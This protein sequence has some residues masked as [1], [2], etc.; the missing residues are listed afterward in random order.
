MKADDRDERLLALGKPIAAE[1]GRGE[2]HTY[3][4]RLER[5]QYLQVA[6][7]PLG[8]EVALALTEPGGKRLAEAENPPG[9]PR[10]ER[11]LAIAET[12]GEH[13]VEV[14][15]KASRATA[16]RY[17]VT[18]EELRAA[19]TRDTCRLEAARAFA[20]GDRLTDEGTAASLA[21]AM[22]RLKDALQFWRLGEDLSGEAKT[23]ANIG[24]VHFL[25]GDKPKALES[26]AEALSLMEAVGD[27]YGEGHT[28]N[29]IGAVY[30]TLGEKRK[31]IEYY[32]R[33][34]L[35]R[36]ALGDH[37]GEA[38]V[39]NN[40]GGVYDDL[41]EKQKAIGYLREALSLWDVVGDRYGEAATRNV[42]GVVYDTLG[43]KP[44]ALEYYEDALR[45]RREIRDL[46][47][48]EETMRNIGNLHASMGQL[49]RALDYYRA[50][51]PLT[52]ETGARLDEASALNDMGSIY[53]ALG[54]PRKALDYYKQAF[55]LRQ[56]E[57]DSWGESETLRATGDAYAALGEHQTA[58]EYFQRAIK[59]QREVGNRSQEVITWNRLGK[60]HRSMRELQEAFDA[61]S[62]SLSLAQAVGDRSEEAVALAGLASIDAERG[63]PE[64]AV[65][66][67]GR[68][69]ALARAVGDR[70]GEA[71][72]LYELGRTEQGRG[73]L[74]AARTA[75]EKAL[76]IVESLRST[77][78]GERL[79]TSYFASVQQYYAFAIELLMQLHEKDPSSGF[80][81]LGFL[82]AERAR[83]RSLL[84]L[85]AE[86]GAGVREGV[87]P[88]LRDRERSLQNAITAKLERQRHI[89]SG[90]H[91]SDEASAL[92]GEIAQLES[93]CDGVEAQIRATSP[94]YAELTQPSPLTF[95]EI[96]SHV[97]D[98]DTLLLE[99]S[100][101]EERSFLWAVTTEGI[102]SFQLPGRSEIEAVARRVY[103]QLVRGPSSGP[104]KAANLLR[105]SAQL[106]EMVLRPAAEFLGKR[107][108]VV[109]GDGALMFLPFGAL[110]RPTA[111]PARSRAV[112]PL[113]S[114][115][116]IVNLPSASSLVLM[117]REMADR[118]LA[119]KTLVVLADPVFEKGDERVQRA[120]APAK[121]PRENATVTTALEDPVASESHLRRSARDV[122]FAEGALRLP[123][124]PFTRRE[125]RAI[126]DLVAATERR[127][128]F[129]FDASLA[130]ATSVELSQY[131]YVHFATHGLL[132]AANP[133]LSGLVFSLVDR[134]GLDQ[135]GF[136][137]MSEVFN[138]KLPGELVVLSACR[139][140][141]GREVRGEG[142]VGLTR[143]FMYAGTPRVVASLW[144]VDDAATAELM[145]RFYEGMLG[146]KKLRP[147]A[148]LREA[149]LSLM[150][151][152]RW[153]DPYYW[154]GFVLQGEWR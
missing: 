110:P 33:S 81:A 148:A 94:R 126:L 76:E 74:A 93:E 95:G 135:E 44:V 23:L 7:V 117:R 142:L 96:Q 71:A 70:I 111:G 38:T 13:Q 45:L 73:D 121:R 109:V 87:E 116:E 152:P 69:V 47:G 138:L 20:E 134:A 31:A 32:G 68:A 6:V 112:L 129:D 15:S 58:V 26:L 27:R 59:S 90:E 25:L 122:G 154:A 143:A 2:A 137:P 127:E 105:G 89:L 11:I 72:I 113:V 78:S 28:L 123:R 83:A 67:L 57:D 130:T 103:E 21:D 80:D 99:Y 88:A 84:D 46:R 118:K 125:G 55:A 147:A 61:Y 132:D 114:D 77:L 119:P 42:I 53:A 101:G 145:K 141:L 22:A 1:L 41:G 139:T 106:S 149:Q 146:E 56:A 10:P 30:D 49:Q 75:I 3:R 51:L 50:A 65:E 115:H 120:S 16:G 79:R 108:L 9:T 66:T 8:F 63:H 131:R 5:G 153:R 85:L 92:A 140:A 151:Q 36:R 98:A 37:S 29:R 14:R 40:L 60:L 86:A 35:I 19:T 18:V 102:S 104:P 17:E 48:V 82:V 39:L 100:L 34:I 52:R 24:W 136:L 97:L 128:A 144:K 107:R 4:I 150:K 43:E 124:L 64:R 54:E 91:D 12:S 62:Q 133:E